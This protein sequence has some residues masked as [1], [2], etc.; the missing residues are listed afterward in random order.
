M[1][2]KKFYEVEVEF[3]DNIADKYHETPEYNQLVGNAIKGYRDAGANFYDHLRE[4]ATFDTLE[5]AQRCERKLLDV[6]Y[7]LNSKE[8]QDESH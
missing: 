4:W 2:I 8:V 3:P 1:S 7:Y 6:V 5:D